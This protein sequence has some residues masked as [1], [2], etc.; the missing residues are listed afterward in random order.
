MVRGALSSP[1]RLAAPCLE[2]NWVID[3]VTVTLWEHK[4]LMNTKLD[5][6]YL[7]GGKARRG[8]EAYLLD[9]VFNGE[10]DPA[11]TWT[12]VIGPDLEVHVTI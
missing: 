9:F 8:G 12:V 6:Q 10:F 1:A 5:Q 4:I 11:Q 7:P 3:G 2:R